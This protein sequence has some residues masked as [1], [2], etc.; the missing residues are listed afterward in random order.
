MGTE[1]LSL[2][3]PD[4]AADTGVISLRN[5]IGGEW[6]PAEG[7]DWVQ[8][9]NPATGRLFARCPNS[10]QAEADRAVAAAKAAFWNWRLTPLPDRADM[11]FA[12]KQRLEDARDDLAQIITQE[13]GK[14]LKESK[15]ELMRALQY[16]EDACCVGQTMRG[17]YTED[18]AHGVDEYSVREPLG[19]FL[20]LPPFNFPAMIACYFVWAVAC[21][22]TVVIKPSSQT[23]ATIHYI[24]KLAEEVGFPKGVI[25]IIN[26]SGGAIGDHL[27]THP[28]IAGVSFVGSSKVGLHIYDL[29]CSRG[30]RA[31][32]QGGAKNHVLVM[33]DAVMESSV[34]NVVSSCFGHVGERCFAVSNVLVVESRYE[35][36]KEKFIAAAKALKV[37]N[38]L[39]PAT[40]LGPVVN[41]RAL[42]NLH[43]QIEE[44]LAEGATMLLDGRNPDVPGYPDGCFI[45]PTILEAR[46]GMQIFEEE[47]FGPVR[48]MMKVKDLAEAIDI[49]NANA[50]GHTAVIYTETAKYARSF[51]QRCNVGQVG[52]NIGTPAPISFYPVGGRK[53]S[54]FGSTRGR[55]ADAVDFYTDK[56]VVVS[57]WLTKLEFESA[58]DQAFPEWSPA[59]GL[60]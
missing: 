27:L 26:G 18:I 11:M 12:F 38:G 35:E 52:V 50:Y 6:V 57:R 36:F 20:I 55:A 51:G 37:G 14:T 49:I 46:P 16:V 5:Y 47:A 21:G 44:G 28:D 8:V 32:V 7:D 3:W 45:G 2:D 4:A 17:D 25:N 31:Q 58:T 19:V 34:N 56:K 24:V 42:E 59:A 33:E 9:I 54:F 41:K 1:I 13:H 53:L 39:D 15:D 29:A 43:R 30:K 40:T 23:P 10:S 22:N 60:W 48:C